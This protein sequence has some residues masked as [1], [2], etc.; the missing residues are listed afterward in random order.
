[1]SLPQTIHRVP[2]PVVA[3]DTTLRCRINRTWY[4]NTRVFFNGIRVTVAQ[5]LALVNHDKA[6]VS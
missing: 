4:A 1:M 3:H 5:I 2:T 6:K